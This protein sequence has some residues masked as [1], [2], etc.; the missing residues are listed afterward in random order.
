MRDRQSHRG[1]GLKGLR[2][3]IVGCCSRMSRG[4]STLSLRFGFS[5]NG[6]L[7]TLWRQVASVQ[8]GVGGAI[9]ADNLGVF[10]DADDDG[11]YGSEDSDAMGELW[12]GTGATYEVGDEVLQDA[13]SK[14]GKKESPQ[15]WL[16]VAF[17]RITGREAASEV[18]RHS[19]VTL[20]SIDEVAKLASA[21]FSNR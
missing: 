9:P 17:A 15:G 18:L 12:A 11:G 7:E 10:N 4:C 2:S 20:A 14:S 8:T 6:Y 19:G 3:S 5:A 21:D 1:T 16:Q 13:G